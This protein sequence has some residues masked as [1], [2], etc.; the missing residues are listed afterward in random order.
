MDFSSGYLPIILE[1][2]VKS[3]ETRPQDSRGLGAASDLGKSAVVKKIL[4]GVQPAT[5]Q[6]PGTPFDNR[7]GLKGIQWLHPKRKQ[8]KA[9][10]SVT[11]GDESG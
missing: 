3:P 4:S 10:S 1:A 8:M 2:P 11:S 5:F 7:Y 6:G 9:A